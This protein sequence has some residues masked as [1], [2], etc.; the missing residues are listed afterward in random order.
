MTHTSISKKW[1][2]SRTCEGGKGR[3]GLRKG[4]DRVGK[5][6]LSA[7]FFLSQAAMLNHIMASRWHLHS[8]LLWRH[9]VSWQQVRC[10]VADRWLI[11]IHSY[12]PWNLRSWLGMQAQR[13]TRSLPFAGN[14]TKR[15]ASA[16]FA[17]RTA[18]QILLDL[19]SLTNLQG[20]H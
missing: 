5:D 9:S 12:L 14:V 15:S 3:V 6:K 1:A 17:R 7:V 8:E 20:F 16:V 11:Q 4:R 19:Y 10:Q 18:W 13:I 2:G